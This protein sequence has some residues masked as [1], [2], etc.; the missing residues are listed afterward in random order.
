KRNYSHVLAA[1]YGAPWAILPEK[2]HELEV[3]LWRRIESGPL[4]L[5]TSELTQVARQKMREDFQKL[6]AGTG[7]AQP[8]VMDD[9]FGPSPDR[10]P[11]YTLTGAAA[12]IPV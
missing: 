11:G 3:V 7:H 12:V 5:E 10:G 6:N 1:F 8:L 9:G 4:T 2:F